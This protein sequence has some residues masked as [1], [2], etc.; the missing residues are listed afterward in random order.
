MNAAWV[1]IHNSQVPGSLSSSAEGFPL[2]G[3]KMHSQYFEPYTSIHFVHTL[4]ILHFFHMSLGIHI[5]YTHLCRSALP[6]GGCEQV[7]TESWEEN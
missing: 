6:G 5:T 1:D 2:D 7:S 3:L 4:S